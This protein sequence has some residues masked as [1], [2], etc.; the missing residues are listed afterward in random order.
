MFSRTLAGIVALTLSPLKAGGVG[1]GVAEGRATGEDLAWVGVGTT[2]VDVGFTLTAADFTRTRV[3]CVAWAG[4]LFAKAVSTT[5]QQSSS[6]DSNTTHTL[7]IK[8]LITSVRLYICLT[9][10]SR[11]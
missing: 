8:I 4:S 2:F 3:V 10:Y 11:G 9:H 1:I 7:R 5:P 6:R